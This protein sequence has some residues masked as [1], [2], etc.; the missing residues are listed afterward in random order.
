MPGAVWGRVRNY[1]YDKG[2]LDIAHSS[3]FVISVGNLTWGGTG[4]TALTAQIAAQLISSG[5]RTAVISRGY[6][7]KSKGFRIVSDGEGPILGWQNAGDEPYWIASHVSDLIVLVSE[8]RREA[9]KFLEKDPP[10]VILLDDGF[11]NRQIARDLDLVLVDVSEA[12]LNQKVI[13]FGKLREPLDSI[14]RADALIL[15]HSRMAQPETLEWI[16]SHITVPIFHGNYVAI[17]EDQG[18]SVEWS[19]KKVA[20]FCAVG[21]PHHFFRMLNDYGADIVFKKEF[22]DHHSYTRDNL[23][24]LQAGAIISGAEALIT[25]QKDAVKIENSWLRLPIVIVKAELQ[26]EEKATFFDLIQERILA[27]AR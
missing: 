15:T 25:T 27:R 26:L 13:P 20:A 2:C 9:L 8:D 16:A 22:R 6:G 3:S 24:E 7:R 1:L 14:R 17:S 4:K 11:Q 21:A 5:Y 19:G 18:R 23:E 10:H 12:L